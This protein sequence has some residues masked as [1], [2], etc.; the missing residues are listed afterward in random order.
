MTDFSFEIKSKDIAGRIG[1]AV[2][3][4]KEIETPALM[5]VYNINKQ[6]IPIEELVKEFKVKALMTNA[7]TLL[8]NEELKSKVLE[9]GIHKL[10]GYDGIVATDSGSY[11]LMVYGSVN[12]TNKEI[13]E[14][15]TR[16]G[17]DIGS[18]LDI[19]T[20]PDAFK[21]RAEEQLNETLKRAQEA[22]NAEF[23]VNAGIQGGKH[24]D[25]REKA[26]R[27]IGKDFDL[28]AIGGIVPL[29]ESYRFKELV[30]IIATVKKNAPLNRLVHAFGLGHPM[31]FGI[32]VAL[33][34]DL[35]DSAAY[36][37]YAQ[38]DRY[39]TTEGTKHLS[40]LDYLPCCCPVC[41]KY[42]IGMKELNGEER[43]GAIARHN[44][45]VSLEEINKIKQAIRENS[46]WE[47]IAVRCRSHPRL[48]EGFERMLEHVEWLAQLDLI[49][50]KSAFKV[51]G[52]ESERRSEVLNVKKR[53]QQVDSAC[54]SEVRIFG[55][56]P[57]EL[58][59]IYPF[60][61]LVDDYGRQRVSD[62]EKVKALMDYQFGQGAGTLITEKVRIKKSRTTRRIRWMYEGKEMIA[63]VRASDHFIIPHEKLAIRL[64]EKFESPKLRVIM[65][66]DEDAV[67]FVR[68]GRSV[69]CKYVRDVDENLRCGDEC[70]VVDVN[71]NFVRTGTLALSPRE[72]K[73]FKRGAAVRV[74]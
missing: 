26:A 11:Q 51:T 13:I 22:I 59:D 34:C 46:L 50:K 25:L 48:L 69:M 32:A 42:G 7:Y 63:S 2:I 14:F 65:T 54:M 29:M 23:T 67:K 19:P 37:L 18:F 64:K 16:I 10:M 66:G 62:L 58:L 31:V 71:D 70:I 74:R 28:I 47:L 55:E 24:L 73:D 56:T 52:P 41:N 61:S 68:E 17:S 30:D 57:A 35:F 49:T 60:N 27:E 39:I 4:K 72:I 21:P 3:N 15:Q 40:E 45:Y 5:P 1:S 43:V 33:G 53:I 6:I 12:T 36:A 20:L 8:K 38:D 9:K 44:L